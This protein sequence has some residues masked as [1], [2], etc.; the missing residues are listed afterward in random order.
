MYF[1]MIWT[2]QNGIKMSPVHNKTFSSA[3]CTIM[4]RI[5][6]FIK[7]YNFWHKFEPCLPMWTIYE[8]K[9]E[10]M[11][12]SSHCAAEAPLLLRRKTGVKFA[13]KIELSPKGQTRRSSKL[14]EKVCCVFLSWLILTPKND[15][16]K[17]VFET[18]TFL[19]TYRLHCNLKHL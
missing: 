1:H 9:N 11:G 4:A 17:K 5:K 15:G 14:Q 13:K 3:P 8:V 7:C 10:W 12:C 18:H 6:L 2:T 19:S 16:N